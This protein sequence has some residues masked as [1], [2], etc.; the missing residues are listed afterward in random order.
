MTTALKNLRLLVEG[1]SGRDG[2]NR[3]T[4]APQ[5][6]KKLAPWDSASSTK[7]SFGDGAP[8]KTRL[9]RPPHSG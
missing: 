8:T 4:H 3:K 5:Y 1:R 2:T 6:T 7:K 9:R